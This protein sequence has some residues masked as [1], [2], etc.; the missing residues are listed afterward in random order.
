MSRKLLRSSVY[1]AVMA[2][3]AAPA[4]AHHGFG[5][6]QMDQM[7]HWSGTLTKMN[8][9]NPHSYMELDAVDASGK[10]QHM[11]CEMRA[12]ALLRRSGLSL[13]HI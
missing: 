9:V 4:L 13:I 7:R 5:L 11:R 10:K 8:L 12:A 6:F 2:G 3:I 1:A